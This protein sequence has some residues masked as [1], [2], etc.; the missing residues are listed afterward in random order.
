MLKFISTQNGNNYIVQ[1][2]PV[3]HFQAEFTENNNVLLKWQPKPDPL[4]STANPEKYIIYTSINDNGFDNGILVDSNE[5][6][7]DKLQPNMIYNFKVTAVNMGGESFSSEILSIALN[8]DNPKPILIIN[9]FDRVSGPAVIETEKFAGFA[10][11]LDAGVPDK[12]SLEFTGNQFNFTPPSK[13]TDDD[14]PGFGSSYADFETFVIP[15][16]TFNY[17]FIHGKAILNAGYS[18]VS[19]SDESLIDNNISLDSY[20]IIDLIYGEEKSTDYPK[21][22]EIKRFEVIPTEMQNKITE[23]LN[24]GGNMFIS[25]S[26]IASDLYTQD[27]DSVNIKFALYTLKLKL[28]TQFAAKTGKV[29]VVDTS[30]TNSLYNFTFNTTYDTTIYAAEAPNGIEPADKVSSKTFIRYKENN[31]SAG[32]IYDGNY[33]IVAI[34]FPFET[35]LKSEVRDRFM[36]NIIQYLQN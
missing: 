36:K 26:Y 30:F 21:P 6:I 29:S 5:Y 28:R 10:N 22:K 34:G 12:Y 25:G 11:F 23:Y 33:K 24:S 3:T 4:E 1:P 9:G 27:I 2:L 16:N 17:P 13:W 19:C 32:I 35:I 8:P 14:S 18:F 15:G 31:I 7:F 20:K